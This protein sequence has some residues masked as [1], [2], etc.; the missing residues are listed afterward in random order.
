MNAITGRIAEGQGT[1]GQLVQ[2]DET[3]KNLNE[4]LVAVK[5]GVDSLTGAMTKV[6]KWNL[7]LGLRAEY[8]ASP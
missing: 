7:D 4:A 2:S 8:L 3:S 5:E 6:K 1:V